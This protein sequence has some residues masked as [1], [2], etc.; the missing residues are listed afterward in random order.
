MAE[1][2]RTGVAHAAGLPE[3]FVDWFAI[4]GPVEVARERFRRLAA[5][6]LDFCYVIPGSTGAPRDVVAGS[7]LRLGQDVLPVLRG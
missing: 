3:A 6:G 7:L 1:H 2:T 4:A 5:L